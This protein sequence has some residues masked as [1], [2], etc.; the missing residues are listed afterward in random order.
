VVLGLV[1]IGELPARRAGLLIFE[2]DRVRTCRATRLHRDQ[3]ERERCNRRH[4]PATPQRSV[5]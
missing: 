2:H 1:V 3:Y 4:E 5:T